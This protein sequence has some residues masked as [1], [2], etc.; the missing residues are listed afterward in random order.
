ME[1]A[2]Q[3]LMHEHE[4]ILKALDIIEAIA[5]KAKY[6]ENAGTA[7]IDKMIDFLRG[8][9]D[10]CHHGKEEELLFPALEA[11]GI[12]KDNGP[13]GIMLSHHTTGRQLI[14]MMDDAVKAKPFQ[15]AAFAEAVTSYVDLM[16]IHIQKENMVLFP[17]GDNVL[18]DAKQKELLEKFELHEKNVV[19]ERKHEEYHVLLKNFQIKY[20]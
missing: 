13:I 8:F 9:A 2:S 4:A 11:A 14:N 6:D 17:M 3:D 10:K 20:L 15:A 19:G 7:D 1:R 18:P 12:R 5:A 16:R